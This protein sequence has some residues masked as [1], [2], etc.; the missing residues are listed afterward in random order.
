MLQLLDP[1]NMLYLLLIFFEQSLLMVR[2]IILTMNL[3]K[4]VLV[5]ALVGAFCFSCKLLTW[6]MIL[7]FQ[8]LV[9]MSVQ[10]GVEVEV[11]GASIF[12]GPI[13]QLVMILYPLQVSKAQLL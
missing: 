13:L 12:I 3:K 1:W 2:R 5:E 7:F 9:V 4:G 10:V 8:R 11:G 6:G